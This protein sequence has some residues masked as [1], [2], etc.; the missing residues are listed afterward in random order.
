MNDQVLSEACVAPLS[1]KLEAETNTE[2]KTTIGTA[3]GLF[4]VS[5]FFLNMQKSLSGRQAVRSES[6][7]KCDAC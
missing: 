3:L 1:G 7:D 4:N 5:Y 6:D 2:L